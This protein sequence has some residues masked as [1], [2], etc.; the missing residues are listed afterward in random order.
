MVGLKRASECVNAAPT[1][2]PRPSPHTPH[3]H[4]TTSRP[5][6]AS[7]IMT[8]ILALFSHLRHKWIAIV[9]G[10]VTPTP[11]NQSLPKGFP[12]ILFPPKPYLVPRDTLCS[13][14]AYGMNLCTRRKK[15]TCT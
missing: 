2:Q 13:C 7:S 8:L 15:Y 4:S 1:N 5:K 10:A 14:E 6:Q 12:P 11:L 9:T 3:F